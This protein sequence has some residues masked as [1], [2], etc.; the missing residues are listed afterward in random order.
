MQQPPDTDIL[1]LNVTVILVP[2]VILA[3]VVTVVV[4]DATTTAVTLVPA[5]IPVPDIV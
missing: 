2:V 5:V 1:L 3:D 4:P